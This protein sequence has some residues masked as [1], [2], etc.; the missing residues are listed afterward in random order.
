MMISLMHLKRRKIN[1]AKIAINNQQKTYKELLMTL[2]R[3]PKYNTPE[4]MQRLIDLYFLACRAHQDGD[5]KRLEGIS[6]EDLLIVKDVE[7]VVPTVSGLAY[8][9]NMSRQ[10]ICDY[11]KKDRF[12]DT[13][14][15]AK[16]RIEMSLENRLAG[17]AVTGSIFNLKNNFGWKDKTETEH[18]GGIDLSNKSDAELLAIINDK[19]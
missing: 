10:A 19:G 14:K 16:L 5:T 13:I 18:S 2:G 11:E 7:C 8:I 1:N 6:D 4:E 15:R 12:L 9:L 3:P 17:N